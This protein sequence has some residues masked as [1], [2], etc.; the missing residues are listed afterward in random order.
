MVGK[1]F[2]QPQNAAPLAHSMAAGASIVDANRIGNRSSSSSDPGLV[3]GTVDESGLATPSKPGGLKP[4][5]FPLIA[6]FACTMTGGTAAIAFLSLTALPPETDCNQAVAVETDRGLLFCV[7]QAAQ[8]GDMEQVLSGLEILGEWTPSDPLYYEAQSSLDEWSRIV[9][10]KARHQLHNNE[11]DEAIA[12][13]G[14]VPESSPRYTEAQ[15]LLAGWQQQAEDAQTIIGAAQEALQQKDWDQVSQQIKSLRELTAYVERT[16]RSRHLSEQLKLEQEN[17]R[18]FQSA[19][20]TAKANTPQAIGLAL[21]QASSIN[22]NTYVWQSAEPA[23]EPLGRQL[24]TYGKLQWQQGHL[25]NALLT[26]QRVAIFEAL[27][28]EAKNLETLAQ[29]RK[30]AIATVTN[31]VPSHEHLFN[32]LEATAAVRQIPASSQFYAQAQDSLKSWEA[33]FAD[34]SHLQLAKMSAQVGWAPAVEW[35][36][37]QA[38][39]LDPNRPRRVQAQTLAAHWNQELERIKDRRYII[40]ANKLAEPGTRASL[41]MAILEAEKVQR[42]RPLFGEA[43]G[44]IYAWTRE[45]QTQEDQPYMNLAESLARQGEYGEAIK[46]AALIQSGRPLHNTARS[47]INQWQQEIWAKRQAEQRRLARRNPSRRVVRVVET[48]EPE[49]ETKVVS[50]PAVSESRADTTA[51]PIADKPA[52]E[53][54]SQTVE[55]IAPPIV[56]TSPSASVDAADNNGL[57]TP[58]PVSAPGEGLQDTGSTGQSEVVEQ[59][60]VPLELESAPISTP[61][62]GSTPDSPTGPEAVETVAPSPTVA[63]PAPADP[64]VAEPVVAEPV[65]PDPV[66]PEAAPVEAA[67]PAPVA[68]EPVAVP[69]ESASVSDNAVSLNSSATSGDANKSAT[70]T[71]TATP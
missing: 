51:R 1:S 28:P 61:E 71:S 45:I 10:S 27:A 67:A 46:T 42:D 53:S 56:V 65:V 15:E 37:N 69:E 33:Q 34:V 8:S 16:E 31:W 40:W 58:L 6:L 22:K 14:K 5:S 47:A 13:V 49:V 44:L 18:I 48:R 59:S 30:L 24:L 21:Q 62:S 60:P 11:I 4:W 25:D 19:L 39:Q 2:S 55:A 29:A 12:L 68:P 3:E 66:V 20:D 9:L 70:D 41:K 52:N 63:P 36:A 7:Q 50:T 35:A 54:P 64:V 32:L 43:Q 38:E 57:V 17:D 26:A 23:L